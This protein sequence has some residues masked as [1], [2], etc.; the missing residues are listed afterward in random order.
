MMH[1][2]TPECAFG[3]DFF[4]TWGLSSILEL[5]LN[6]HGYENLESN[7]IGGGQECALIASTGEPSEGTLQ[8]G[9]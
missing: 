8:P 6:K 2:H 5:P 1:T 7:L 4:E 3:E 9:T